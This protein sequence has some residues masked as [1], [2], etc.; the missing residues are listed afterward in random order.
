MDRSFSW[1]EGDL[2]IPVRKTRTQFLKVSWLLIFSILT[3]AS[4]VVKFAVQSGL[5]MFEN[6]GITAHNLD[7]LNKVLMT[8]KKLNHKILT[9]PNLDFF[10]TR[11]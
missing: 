10:R 4:E 9:S 2:N 3:T 8:Q 5:Q 7:I 1:K 6:L 11:A